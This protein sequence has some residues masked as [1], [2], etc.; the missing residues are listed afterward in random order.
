MA[1]DRLRFANIERF[2]KLVKSWATG[3]NYLA[4]GNSYVIPGDLEE[5]RRQNA[6]AQTGVHIPDWAKKIKFVACEP[7][8]I[9]IRVPPKHM[10]ED[11]EE[12]LSENGATYPIP[13]MYKKIFGGLDPVIAKEQL[14][15]FHASRIGEYT[16][17]L[18]L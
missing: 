9:V 14:L 13:D 1:I 16:S 15:D 6:E 12:R 3:K 17:N 7:D 11:S 5:F 4:D 2:G 10:I 8:T 18:C